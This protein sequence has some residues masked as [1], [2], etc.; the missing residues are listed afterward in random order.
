MRLP[1]FSVGH[2][3]RSIEDFVQ[4]LRL[5]DVSTV[6]DIR[7]FPNSRSNPQFNRDALPDRLADF[8]LGY[9]HV[10]ELGGRRARSP[11]VPP[12]V[13]AFWDNQSFHNYA[14]YA[15]SD[16][17]RTGLE[18]L[19]ALGRGERCAMMC[20]EA[21]WWRCHRRIV[22]DHLIARGERVFHLMGRDRIEPATMTA[23]ARVAAEGTVTYPAGPSAGE[24]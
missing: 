18:R 10:P 4:L 21:V 13:N 22:A 6:A 14:D 9:A 23:G 11:S 24:A 17:F 15:L 1:F 12:E 16:G 19:I 20:A 5:A 8:R 3:D 2:S 7:T